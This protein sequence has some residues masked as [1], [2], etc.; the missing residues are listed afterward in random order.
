MT[1]FSKIKSF[2]AVK[3]PEGI[4]HVMELASAPLLQTMPTWLTKGTWL[5]TPDGLGI[6]VDLSAYNEVGVMLVTTD[7]GENVEQ[8]R[9]DFS[10]IRLAYIDEFPTLRIRASDEYFLT[11]GY[12]Y[13][14]QRT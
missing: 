11:K 8:R 14:S 4:E 5:M 6:A 7:T 13:G 9:Y 12:S 3:E 1:L 10:S 2:F